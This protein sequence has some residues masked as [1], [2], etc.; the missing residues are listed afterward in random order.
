VAWAELTGVPL[1]SV[2]A[3]FHYVRSGETVVPLDLPDRAALE[4]L[5]TA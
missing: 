5:L 2:T 1:S 3:A 4:A